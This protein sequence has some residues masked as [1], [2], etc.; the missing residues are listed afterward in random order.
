MVTLENIVELLEKGELIIQSPVYKK[1]RFWKLCS[2]LTVKLSTGCVIDIPKG[3]VYDMATVPKILWSFSPPY[4]DA[5]IA[6]L[7]HDWLYVHQET[8]NLTRKQADL[9]LLIWAKVTNPN[10]LDNYIKWF[11]SR[12]L[13]Y[14]WWSN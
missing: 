5:L 4:D 2:P 10:K 11:F 9:E 13:G 14:F 8:H 3:Y 7:I 1:D 12:L 6:F